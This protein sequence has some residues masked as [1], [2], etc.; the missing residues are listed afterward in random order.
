M[1]NIQQSQLIDNFGRKISYLR[2]SVTDRCDLRCVY[3]MSEDMTFMPRAKLLTLEEI[4]RIAQQYVDMG[5]NKI[6]ITGGE[7]LT[8]R[9]VIKLFNDLGAMNGLNDLTVTTNGTL[10]TKY[11]EDLKKAGVTR[12]N[13]SLD[14]LQADRFKAIT[15]I[16]DIQK[17]LDG[18]DA[19]LSQ[20][21]QSV[22]LNA[23]IMKN[24]ND[25]EILDLVNYVRERG[26]DISF[27][28][29]MPLGDMGNHDRDKTY[30]SSDEVLRRI[31]EK[32]NLIPSTETTGGPS[33]YYRSAD[34]DSKIGFISPHSHNFCDDC[35][36]VRITAEGRLLLCLG[37]EHSMDLRAVVRAHPTDDAVL[38]KAIID[39][40]VLKPKGHDF[41]VTAKPIIMRHMSATGG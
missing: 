4:A 6:R 40:M 14:T 24:H 33:R 21:F 41:D 37:Q 13:V 15:R 23:V 34:S 36:R 7:P 32:Y 35:N 10:L 39:S 29:E 28:E 17:T 31:E 8:R 20:N 26:L 30:C 5:V 38:R 16:G 1:S 2:I 12:I 22:K 19:A 25:D 3:C 11:A 18:I 27:I 9:N